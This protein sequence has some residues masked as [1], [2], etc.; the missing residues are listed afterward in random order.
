MDGSIDLGVGALAKKTVLVADDDEVILSLLTE[1]LEGVDWNVVSASN[2]QETL[3]LAREHQPD[4]V[5]AD[6]RMPMLTGIEVFQEL[7]KEN[8]LVPFI[9]MTAA[10]NATGLSEILGSRNILI[11]PFGVDDL[12]NLIDEVTKKTATSAP[13]LTSAEAEP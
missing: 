8:I 4:L 5:I 11:K 6:L 10:K 12:L 9:L 13:K 7:R 2:G 3:E 1:I